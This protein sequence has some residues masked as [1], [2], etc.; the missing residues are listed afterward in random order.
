MEVGVLGATGTVGQR[1]VQ[2]LTNHPWFELA[3]VAASDRSAGRRYAEA[4]SWQLEGA[5]P[6]R[7]AEMTV[8]ECR[9]GRG[10]RLVFS[11]MAGDL[12]GEIESEFAKAGHLVVSNS[13]HFRMAADVPLLVPEINPAHLGLLCAQRRERGW[14]DTHHCLLCA[15]TAARE[16]AKLR[17]QARALEPE[18]LRGTVERLDRLLAELGEDCRR[19]TALVEVE[20]RRG[21]GPAGEAAP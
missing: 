21:K 10:P 16:A 15:R 20:P 14:E 18:Y 5:P 6:A 12:A 2:L 7:A 11:S 9:P 19:F 13:S 1:F 3:W 17:D 4:T 8:D